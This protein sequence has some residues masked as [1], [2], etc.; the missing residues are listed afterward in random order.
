MEEGGPCTSLSASEAELT[1]PGSVRDPPGIRQ[2]V[3]SEDA[4]HT[5]GLR[6]CTNVLVQRT[7]GIHP[8]HY[9]RE[10]VCSMTLYFF[11]VLGEKFEF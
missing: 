9:T 5:S 10:S 1:A 3:I 7:N 6:M 8:F 11:I 4:S 2:T